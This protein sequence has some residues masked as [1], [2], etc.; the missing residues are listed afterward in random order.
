MR[1]TIVLALAC[2]ASLACSSSSEREDVTRTDAGSDAASAEVQCDPRP[3]SPAPSGSSGSSGSGSSDGSLD[4]G[5]NFPGGPAGRTP[6][7]LNAGE[8]A[9]PEPACSGAVVCC[10]LK[11]E[12]FNPTTEPDFCDRPYCEAR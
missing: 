2:T 7:T 9:P 1:R 3:V 8:G 5:A 10:E 4:G 11:D 6:C 12:C